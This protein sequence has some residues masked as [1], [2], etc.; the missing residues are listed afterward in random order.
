M[1]CE[2]FSNNIRRYLYN[3]SFHLITLSIMLVL[4]EMELFVS[5]VYPYFLG[6]CLKTFK[7]ENVWNIF[8]QLLCGARI[9]VFFFYFERTKN[10]C[11]PT[12]LIT[13]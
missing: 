12:L 3:S 13:C 8:F 11:F 1:R 2:T 4:F 9:I 10:V 5:A 6:L 7:S